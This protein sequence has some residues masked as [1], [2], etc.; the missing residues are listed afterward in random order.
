MRPHLE[1]LAAFLVDMR[2]A[3]HGELLDTGR[4]RDGPANFR[5]GAFRRIDNFLG[6][7]I[8]NAMVEGFQPDSFVLALNLDGLML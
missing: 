4:Q 8:E 6:R 1:L 3:V 2:R 5:T 7:R